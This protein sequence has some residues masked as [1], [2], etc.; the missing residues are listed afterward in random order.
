MDVFLGREADDFAEWLRLHPG[1]Q[2]ICRDR[3]GGYANPWE[4]HQTG[5]EIADGV[6][7][8]KS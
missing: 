7:G 8:A 1:V 6:A 3:A 5:E 2:V 4:L